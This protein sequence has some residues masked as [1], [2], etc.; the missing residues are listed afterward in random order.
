MKMKRRK[1]EAEDEERRKR[2]REIER[3]KRLGENKSV[4][5]LRKR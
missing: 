4:W 5:K 3:I 1:E 2:W